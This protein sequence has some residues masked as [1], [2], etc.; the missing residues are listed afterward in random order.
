MFRKDRLSVLAWMVLLFILTVPILNV[1]FVVWILIRRRASHTV[2]NFF[3]AY[4]VFYLL[5]IFGM[6]NG[7]FS[8]MQGLFG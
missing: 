8:N 6:F 5:A 7:V 2:K 3:L 4:G 1:I